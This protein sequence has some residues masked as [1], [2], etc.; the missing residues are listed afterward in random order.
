M[1][2][3][4]LDHLIDEH[5]KVLVTACLGCVYLVLWMG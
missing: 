5:N 2:I 4:M 1:G 3:E